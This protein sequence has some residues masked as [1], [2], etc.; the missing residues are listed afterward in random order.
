MTLEPEIC[1][2]GCNSWY[3]GANITGKPR[4]FMPWLGY[5]SYVEKCEQ[6]AS[7]GYRG[8]EIS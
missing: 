2:P 4:I 7:A 6:V 8:F 1:S 3:T 5:P